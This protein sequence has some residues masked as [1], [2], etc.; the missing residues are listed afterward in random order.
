MG[1]GKGRERRMGAEARVGEWRRGQG[2]VSEQAGKLG[3]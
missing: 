3:S 1:G 2:M